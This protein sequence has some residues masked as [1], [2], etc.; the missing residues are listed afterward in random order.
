MAENKN[1]SQWKKY[2]EDGGWE[3]KK[4]ERRKAGN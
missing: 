1:V 4:E 2:G 3:K